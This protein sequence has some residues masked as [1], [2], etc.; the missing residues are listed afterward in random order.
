MKSFQVEIPDIQSS[1]PLTAS[2]E[3]NS[4][5]ST[6]FMMVKG[7]GGDDGFFGFGV[8]DDSKYLEVNRVKERWGKIVHLACKNGYIIKAIMHNGMEVSSSEVAP[9]IYPMD[10]KLVPIE[11]QCGE[12]KNWCDNVYDDLKKT[13]EDKHAGKSKRN[14]KK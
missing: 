12:R 2:E 7:T 14:I 11:K 6:F 5:L 10:R 8:D 3:E 1:F 4:F 13:E 9:A